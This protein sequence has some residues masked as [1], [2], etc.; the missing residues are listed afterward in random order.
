MKDRVK[1]II[2]HYQLSS[3]KFADTLGVQRSSIS[4]IL[5]GRNK[6]S[7]DIVK[8]ILKNFTEINPEWLLFGVDEM[9][10]Y[11]KKESSS[12]KN[13]ENVKIKEEPNEPQIKENVKNKEVTVEKKNDTKSP[14]KNDKQNIENKSAIEFTDSPERI[15][16]LF[17]DNTFKSYESR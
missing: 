3:S 16:V 5:S 7:L 1:S 9:L 2:E 4:H 8:R 12:E 15:I 10:K 6:T 14:E 17:G 13:E 11:K